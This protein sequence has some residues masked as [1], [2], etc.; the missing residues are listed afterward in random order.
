M[1]RSIVPCCA[2]ILAA[3]AAEAH[4][5]DAKQGTPGA[6]TGPTPTAPTTAQ[7]GTKP[8]T[9]P[10]TDLEAASAQIPPGSSDDVN[11]Q[12]DTARP[13]HSGILKNG[14]VS[15]LD[16]VIDDMNENLR[17]SAGLEIGLAYTTLWQRASDGEIQDAAAG[18]L[19]LFARWRL[20]GK[21]DSKNRG[22]LGINTEYRHDFGNDAPRDLAADFGGLW[23][24][25][26]G[27]GVQDPEITQCWWEQHLSKDRFVLTAGKIDADNFY[28]EYRYQSDSTAF[29]S[30]AFSSNPAR[31][32]PGNGL[33][34]NAKWKSEPAWYVTGGIQ[35]ANGAKDRSGFHTIDEHEFFVAAEVGFT[36]KLKGLGQGAYRFSWW[37]I[38]ER[39]KYDVRSDWGVGLSCEQEMPGGI[40]PFFRASW[41][42][43]DPTRV[44]RFLSGGVGLEGT[45]G[46]KEDLTGVGLAWGDPE[47]SSLDNEVSAEVF[48]RFQL[49]PD[50]QLT[51]G[52]QYYWDPALAASND[53]D[54]VGVFEIRVRILF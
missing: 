10:T 3:S 8:A 24:T 38:D 26:N 41:A 14:P 23:R 16:P 6:P 30:Q 7:P 43:G 2:L 29:V 37:H 18:D 20:L 9:P 33:G 36:P 11:Y 53:D 17:K 31:G 40:V 13:R 39:D 44:T 48:H 49:A 19:D 5:Q 22:I 42:D 50:V 21:E 32:H 34:V 15:L 47:Q 12:L 27:F 28:N 45:L 54:P 25:S 1:N 4:A 35:D 51:L 52:Y 46:R